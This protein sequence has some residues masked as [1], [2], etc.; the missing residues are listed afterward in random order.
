MSKKLSAIK[1]KQEE[2]RAKEK[3][4]KK[5]E[6][7]K[8]EE[9]AIP[10]EAKRE[11]H[12]LCGVINEELDN[13]FSALLAFPKAFGPKKKRE[14]LAEHAKGMSE[15]L[16]IVQFWYPAPK[17]PENT[18]KKDAAGRILLPVNI[19][20]P[21]FPDGSS[22][23]V[24]PCDFSGCG[25]LSA[26]GKQLCHR[27]EHLQPKPLINRFADGV[28]GVRETALAAFTKDNGR[29]P[30]SDELRAAVVARLAII[31]KHPEDDGVLLIGKLSEATTV[32]RGPAILKPLEPDYLRR[33]TVMAGVEVIADAKK[34][35]DLCEVAGCQAAWTCGRL[36]K[37]QQQN[38][39]FDH[40][41]ATEN[42][43][44]ELAI[45]QARIPHP[46]DEV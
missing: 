39:C 3:A 10:D 29:E 18:E 30:T 16:A 37:S 25:Q 41:V 28:E 33:A 32:V 40:M 24:M 4:A 42:R 1:A 21:K 6:K 31:N 17:P 45:E 7:K 22:A 11:L 38:L 36:E 5:A 15:W 23:A 9:E 12:K 13:L 44:R 19:E 14:E 46:T 20:E 34:P 26:P 2:K 43:A 27:H 35:A 8:A